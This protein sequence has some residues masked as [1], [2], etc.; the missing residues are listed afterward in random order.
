MVTASANPKQFVITSDT[1]FAEILDDPAGNGVQYI[2][3]VPN[4]KRG[5][6]DAVNRRYPTMFETGSGGV[7]ALVLEMR[8]DGGTEPEM[9][10]LYRVTGQL[11]PGG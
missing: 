2:L 3:A 11:T 4:T 9:W 7:G 10:R 1:D 8:N 6:A 5:V